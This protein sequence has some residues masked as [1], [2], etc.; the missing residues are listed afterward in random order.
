MQNILKEI[1]VAG[2]N[3]G[4]D[5][6]LVSGGNQLFHLITLSLSFCFSFLSA[7]RINLQ[8]ATIHAPI[9]SHLHVQSPSPRVTREES[10]M[11]SSFF[12]CWRLILLF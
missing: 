5:S 3:E 10:I 6:I 1:S 9:R 11:F 8:I 2:L 4:F 12:S 7:Q